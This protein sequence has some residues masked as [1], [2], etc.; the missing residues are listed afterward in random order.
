MIEREVVRFLEGLRARKP[1]PLSVRLWTGRKVDLGDTPK[2]TIA[3]R[4]MRAG[5]HLLKPSLDSLGQAYVEGE[6]DFEGPM[7]DVVGVAESLART[8]SHASIAGALPSGA[9][10]TRE[11]DVEAVRYHYDVSNAF[12]ARWLD[13]QMVYSCAYF[14]TGNEDLAA[15]QTAKLDHICRKLRLAAG[16]RLLD[17]GSGW[18]ALLIHAARHYRVRAVG[19]T[20]SRDQAELSKARIH[21]AGLD[22]QIE[23]RLQD[24]RDLPATE[25]FDRI[26]SVG[27]IEHVGLQNLRGYFDIVASRLAPNGLALIHGIT[28]ADP[29]SREVGL[30]AGLFIQRHVFPDGELPHLSRAV[31]EASAAGLEVTDVESLRRHYAR[32]LWFWSDAFESA[33]PELTRMVGERRCRT[34]RA[35]LAGCAHGFAHGWMNIYQL[36]LAKPAVDGSLPLPMSRR[37][38]YDPVSGDA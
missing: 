3:L 11:T 17:I 16:Q 32:T 14:E 19:I 26:A 18:G 8:D 10:H 27:M 34:W 25:Q 24:Y 21:D 35:Y 23:V 36:Q 13:P 4:S 30:G 31:R 5:R 37:Y 12:Y 20:L 6:L 29:D 38:L 22:G 1:L 28:S 15:A 33:L 7:R 2:V 9:R